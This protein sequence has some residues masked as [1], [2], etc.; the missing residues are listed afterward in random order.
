MKKPTAA[1]TEAPAIDLE[2]PSAGGSY[3]RQPDGTLKRVEFTK[4]HA[5][6][7]DDAAEQTPNAAIAPSGDEQKD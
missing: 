4:D 2:Q 5:E 6:Q 3:E 7:A 1:S